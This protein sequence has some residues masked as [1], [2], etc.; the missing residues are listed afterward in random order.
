VVR[1]QGIIE[2]RH[3][4]KALLASPRKC[5]VSGQENSKASDRDQQRD[6][7]ESYRLITKE[8]PVRFSAVGKPCTAETMANPEQR[9]QP[10]VKDIEWA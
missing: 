9:G 2:Y 10:K 8:R 4:H 7:D 6:Y 5:P 3:T 1:Y